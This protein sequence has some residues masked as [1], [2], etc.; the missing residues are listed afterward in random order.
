[1]NCFSARLFEI[2]SGW[3]LL[4]CVGQWVWCFFYFLSIGIVKIK[5]GEDYAKTRVENG[6]KQ[7]IELK[8]IN[9]YKV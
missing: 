4:V 9:E 3:V 7:K 5:L 8:T 6:A 2:C 1:M